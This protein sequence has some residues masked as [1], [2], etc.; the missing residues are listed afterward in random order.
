MRIQ[1]L[2]YFIEVALTGNISTAAKNLYIAQP[3]LSQQMI[4]LEKE[5][6]IQLLIRHSK[7][8]SLSDAGEQFLLHAQRIVG[9]TDQLSELMKK[10][11]LLQAGTLRIGMLWVAAYLNL[12]DA[13]YHYR[14][15]YPDLTYELKIDGSSIL[16]KQ[17]LLRK[18]HAAFIISS[19]HILEQQKELFFRKIIVD[20]YVLVVST[21]NP[22]SEKS[23]I[24][25]QDLKNEPLILPD[26]NSTF[27]KQLFQY[28]DEYFMTPRVICETS[29]PDIVIRLVSQN[30]GV[31]FSSS[32]IASTLK[33][34]EFKILPLKEELLRCVYYVTL[35]ELF[36]YPSIRTFTR[37]IMHHK[38]DDK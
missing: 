29:H 19:D 16:L 24:S 20:R 18:I 36:D 37:Y 7:S 13:L 11:S 6:G 35:K 31:G 3:S 33:T 27:Y 12:P 21:Q 10:H 38:F 23:S 17:L 26:R 4:N 9:E 15:I 8:V 28:F 14:K 5:L 25:I 22:L 34:S 1:Q 2:R 30:F 32:S